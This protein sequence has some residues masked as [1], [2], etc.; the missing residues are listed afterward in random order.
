CPKRV[1]LCPVS[2]ISRFYLRSHTSGK[3]KTI[4]ARDDVGAVEADVIADCG[5]NNELVGMVN[6]LH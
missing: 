1:W 6:V 4:D 5:N 2:R 3:R